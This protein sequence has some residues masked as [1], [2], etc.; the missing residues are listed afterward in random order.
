MTNKTGAVLP[1]RDAFVLKTTTPVVTID[2]SKII[3][4]NKD[5]IAV[6]FTSKHHDFEQEI[7]FDFKIF[8]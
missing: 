4:K 6:Y 5:S 3:L 1:F 2:E 7:S 8:Q